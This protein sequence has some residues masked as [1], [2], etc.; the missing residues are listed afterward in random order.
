MVSSIFS[1]TVS[2]EHNITFYWGRDD[3]STSPTTNE[4][5]TFPDPVM[6]RTEMMDFFHDQYGFNESQVTALMGAH[7]LGGAEI[8]N[9][10]YAGNWVEGERHRWNNKYYALLVGDEI[11]FTKAAMAPQSP[12]NRK[13]QWTLT[14]NTSEELAGFMLHSDVELCYDIDVDPIDGVF[15]TLRGN[16]TVAKTYTLADKYANSFDDWMA[17]FVPVYE[18]MTAL[19]YTDLAPLTE[20]CGDSK[21]VS[22]CPTFAHL[23]SLIFYICWKSA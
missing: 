11:S 6:N 8:A 16:C 5:F 2:K 10:G 12:T 21:G 17:D 13:W 19:G 15:C 18:A 4:N 9:S 1:C 7:T 3:C 23:F 22:L 20:S 14:N